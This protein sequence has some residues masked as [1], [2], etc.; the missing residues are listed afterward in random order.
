[1]YMMAMEMVST[2]SARTQRRDQKSVCRMNLG[3]GPCDDTLAQ[4][5]KRL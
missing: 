1:M 3:S 4:R 2:I 5:V